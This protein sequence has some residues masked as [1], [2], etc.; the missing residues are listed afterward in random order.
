MDPLDRLLVEH[1]AADAVDGVGGIADHRAFAHGL[2][3]LLDQ[4][5]LRVVRIDLKY[6]AAILF[7]LATGWL[8]EVTLYEY[9][10]SSPHIVRD[11]QAKGNSEAVT[12]KRRCV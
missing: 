7:L 2:R 1:I 5:G 9:W 6:H 8:T 11:C 3:R 10:D 4:A 12:G